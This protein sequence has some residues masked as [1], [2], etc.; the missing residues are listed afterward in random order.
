MKTIKRFLAF[1]LVAIFC[2]GTAHA[3]F[4]WGIKAGMNFNKINYK[5]LTEN[6]KTDNRAG[7]EAGLTAEFTVPI[8]GVGMDASVLYSR[9]N[10]DGQVEG[11]D[12][13]E[14]YSHKDF[15]DIPVNLKWKIGVPVVGSIVK[16]MIYTGPDFL[17]AVGN[18]TMSDII[19]THKCEI[20]WNIGVGVELL[21]HLQIQGGYCIGINKIANT[22]V[23]AN[24]VDYKAKKNYWSV[25]AAY[26][27]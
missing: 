6:I 2:A 14:I 1:A 7:W 4:R 24:T 18:D 10:L 13:D 8:V 20:G 5:H 12:K 11:L 16:P 3:D 17:F 23:N 9:M 19:N 22:V 15:I 27:F 21:K 26:L 25:T